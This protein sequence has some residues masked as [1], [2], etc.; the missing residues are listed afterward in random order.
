MKKIFT[1]LLFMAL[2]TVT[3]FAA[4]AQ[5]TSTDEASSVRDNVQKKV[6]E[7]RTIPFAYVGT[8][9]DIAEQTIQINKF[10][11]SK[12]EEEA[13]EIQQ[14]SVDEENTVFVKITKNTTSVKFSDLAIGD[15]IITMGY[16]NGNGVLEGKRILITTSVEPTA[17]KAIF[18]EPSE[19][20]KR[21]LTLTA[22][23]GKEWAVEFGTTWVGP[24]L[25]EIEEGDKVIIVGTTEGNA[26]EA[27]LLH[28]IAPETT[29]E[30]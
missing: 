6:E 21:S 11:F 2:T 10:I 12:V 8:V 25:S 24:E 13:G 9:T 26:L 1:I 4:L 30:E 5:E 22:P 15:F 7:A 19:I 27:R 18:G 23:T 17:R 20:A 29:V 28:I 3:T 16:K 14:I